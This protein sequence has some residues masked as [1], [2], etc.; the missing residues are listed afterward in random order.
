MQSPESPGF[1]PAFWLR[2]GHVNTFYGGMLRSIGVPDYQRQRIDTPDGDFLDLDWLRGDGRRVAILSHG[3]EGSSRRTYMSGM[4]TKLA[5]AGWDI[6]SWNYRGCSGEQNRRLRTY[7]SG[8]TEDLDAV[9]RT[10]QA[11]YDHIDLIGFSLGGNLTL[12]YL[13]ERGEDAPI[14]SA[15]AFSVPCDL[16]ASSRHLARAAALPYMK[17]F[18]HS[19][20]QKMREKADLFPGEI[21]VGDLENLRS[22][23][24]FDDRFTAPLNGFLDAEDY[25]E[26]A[27]SKPYIASIRVRTL[28]ASALDDPFLPSSCYPH[29]EAATNP[30]ITMETPQYGGHVGFAIRRGEFWSERRALSFLAS[31]S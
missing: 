13:G 19:L 31:G 22:F 3:L 4:A 16:A 18:L 6:L 28:I 11:E 5:S 10:A 26:R 7:H 8:A 14:Q 1:R 27:S 21:D 15:V 12:K 29:E 17:R 25:W 24:D 9:V 30:E 20:R 23:R 2:N